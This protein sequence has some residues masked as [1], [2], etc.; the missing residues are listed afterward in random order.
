MHHEPVGL[1]FKAP[2]ADP[3]TEI[4]RSNVRITRPIRRLVGKLQLMTFV[5]RVFR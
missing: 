1:Q 3:F 2:I 4:E 5:E